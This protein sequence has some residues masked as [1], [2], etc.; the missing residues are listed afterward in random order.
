MDEDDRDRIRKAKVLSAL[1][2]RRK[3]HWLTVLLAV[4]LGQFG[5]QRFYLGHVKHGMAICLL[6]IVAAIGV[7]TLVAPWLIYPF[8]IVWMFEVFFG[9]NATDRENERIK[10][11]IEQELMFR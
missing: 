9:T 7:W 4:F 3:K 2:L 11:D 10:A 8:L 6:F 1:S 5:A